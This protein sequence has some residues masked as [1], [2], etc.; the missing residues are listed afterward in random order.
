MQKLEIALNLIEEKLS[1]I[2]YLKDF[3]PSGNVEA[4]KKEDATPAA[5]K[6]QETLFQS[7]NI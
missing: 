1:S 5:G 3:K 7:T 4:E 6:I 2:P